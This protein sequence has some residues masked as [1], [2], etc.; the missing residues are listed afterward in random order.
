MPRLILWRYYLPLSGTWKR[1]GRVLKRQY[2]ATALGEQSSENSRKSEGEGDP[3]E[4]TRS[5]PSVA[6]EP[7]GILVVH[8]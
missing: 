8:R 6:Y 4:L 2:P 1:E 7:I 5:D 3:G